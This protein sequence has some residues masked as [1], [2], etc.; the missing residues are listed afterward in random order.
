VVCGARARDN[1]TVERFNLLTTN[2]SINLN[3]TN[4]VHHET[5]N[6]A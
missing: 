6:D 2:Q 5:G 4:E 1:L 3:D